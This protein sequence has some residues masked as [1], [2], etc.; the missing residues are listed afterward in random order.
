[1]DAV[2]L[3]VVGDLLDAAGARGLDVTTIADAFAVADDAHR[4]Q[5][6]KSGEAYINHPVAVAELVCSL[7]ADTATIAAALLHDVVEDT[8]VTLADIEARFGPQVA[9]LVDG[10]TKVARVRVEQT[11]AALAAD[12]YRKLFVAL[13]ADPRVVVI[14]LCDRLHNLRTIHALPPEKAARIGR[15]TLAVHAPLAHRMGLG[16]IKSELEDRA[17]A[18][19]D[20]QHHA[21]VLDAVHAVTGLGERLDTARRGLVEHLHTRAVHAEVS[22]R[23]KHLWSIARKTDRVGAAPG[24][25]HDLIGLRVVLDTDDPGACYEV[26]DAV[27]QLWPPARPLKDYIARPKFNAYQS[28]HTTVTGPGG[29]P[30]EVQIRTR[31]MHDTAERGPAA[32]HAYKHPGDDPAWLV[33]LLAWQDVD[34]SEYL[35]AVTGELDAHVE[36]YAL[37]PAGDVIVLPEG[38]T[39]VDFAYAVHTDIGHHCVGAKVNGRLLPLSTRLVT[40]DRVEVLTDRRREPSLEWLDWVVTSKARTKIRGHFTRRW[41][42]QARR[43]GADHLAKALRARVDGLTVAQLAAQ[44][45]RSVDELHEAIGSGK[46]TIDQILHRAPQPSASPT[47]S[48][49]SRTTGARV[50][51]AAGLPQV[52]TR[53]AGCCTPAVGD[54]CTGVVHAGSVTVH[55]SSCADLA[56]VLAANPTRALAIWW[57]PEGSEE[58]T[59]SLRTL[60]RP[61]LANEIAAAVVG[62]G[63]ELLECQVDALV[64]YGP[65]AVRVTV[66]AAA[67]PAARK[68]L[69]AALAAL[70]QVTELQLR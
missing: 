15:E 58:V 64:G 5:R 46:V 20:P 32:H 54:R 10:C 67:A 6:R 53:H 18:V 22:G 66:R 35:S 44:A 17:F 56:G 27:H 33:R 1:M 49:P 62:R 60:N 43:S 61:G 11:P 40:G 42:L 70:P 38:A 50:A 48:S 37:T 47:T 26:L 8:P 25:L 21:G 68:H 34:D 28:L 59:V 69:R 3:G 57:V 39:V 45:G 30:V 51:V 29:I 63:A 16:A 13:A 24:D 55:R 12:R 19:A 23:I 14:K 7:G 31:T 41:R 9:G 52:S 65:D 4:D 2:A 36:V